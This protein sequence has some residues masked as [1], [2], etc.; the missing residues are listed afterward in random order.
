MLFIQEITE[1][2]KSH[3]LLYCNGKVGGND[4]LVVKVSVKVKSSGVY[5]ISVL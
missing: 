4:L 1:S 5:T 2:I 3:Y